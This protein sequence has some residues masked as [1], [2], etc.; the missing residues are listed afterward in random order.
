MKN[1]EVNAKNPRCQY[2][3]KIGSRC[4]ADVQTG[5][6]YCFFHDPGQKDKQAQAR[7][8]GG[9][10][11]SHE[12]DKITMPPD[13][14][15]IPLVTPFDVARLLAETI[16]QFRRKEIDLRAAKAISNMASLLLRSLKDAAMQPASAPAMSYYFQ[17]REPDKPKDTLKV[18]QDQSTV[19]PGPAAS[20][21]DSR[22]HSQQYWSQDSRG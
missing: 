10:A 2:I 9:E 11:R 16:N 18:Q 20:P 12:I 3:S 4:H 17:S 7:K 19:S 8:Q 6:S 14:P 22:K 1:A 21:Q 15:V 5:K 13:L